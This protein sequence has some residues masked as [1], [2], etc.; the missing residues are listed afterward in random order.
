MATKIYNGQAIT[1]STTETSYEISG[2]HVGPETV[3]TFV[4]ISGTCQATITGIKENP[5]LDSS[6][7]TWS[8]AGDRWLMT[9]SPGTSNLRMKCA[10]SGVVNINW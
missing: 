1:L 9:I 3:L 2:D 7:A 10:S 8:T 4:L 5:V 6:Y